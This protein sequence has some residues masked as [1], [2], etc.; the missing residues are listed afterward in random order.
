MEIEI[1]VRSPLGDVTV[2]NVDRMSSYDIEVCKA[3]V[4][5]MLDRLAGRV[6]AAYGIASKEPG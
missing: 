2:R 1:T 3:Q 5:N 6:R 4:A